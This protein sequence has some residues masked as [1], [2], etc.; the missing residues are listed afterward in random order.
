MK[1]SEQTNIPNTPIGIWTGIEW[2]QH[3]QPFNIV[4]CFNFS[5]AFTS[6]YNFK[7]TN[8]CGYFHSWFPEIFFFFFCFWTSDNNW[9]LSILI[10]EWD[11]ENLYI[12]LFVVQ[13]FIQLRFFFY[14]RLLF[15]FFS[16]IIFFFFYCLFNGV[17]CNI[18]WMNFKMHS[19]FEYID[20]SF[21]E[22]FNI[23][24]LS[25]IYDSKRI[26]VCHRMEV[27]VRCSISMIRTY[28]ERH[29]HPIEFV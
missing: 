20:W 5:I 21:H 28:T 14:A 29:K 15:R 10:S 13:L 27:S 6:K 24:G 25:V 16:L 7:K 8:A 22:K 4:H 18:I 12:L 1:F 2:S 19:H 23:V 11:I 17:T 9:K 26:F 3:C